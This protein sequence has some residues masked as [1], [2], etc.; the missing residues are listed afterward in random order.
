VPLIL[1]AVALILAPIALMPLALVL[2]YRAGTARRQARGWVATLNLVALAIST[3]LFLLG[4][5]LTSI[6]VPH[7]LSYSLLGLLGGIA[8]GIIGLWLSRWERAPQSLHYTP[9]RWLV[10]GVTLVVTA[11]LLY[12]LWRGWN[13]W[14]HA[15]ETS[16]LAAFGVAGSMAAGAVV[17]GYYLSYWMGVLRRLRQHP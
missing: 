9:N 3:S 17:L 1:L 5:G 4:A 10:L 6:W 7:A 12:G 13:T 15:G 14:R 2:R 11:R 8:L 16:W